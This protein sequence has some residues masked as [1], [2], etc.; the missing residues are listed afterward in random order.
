MMFHCDLDGRIPDDVKTLPEY[1]KQ[2]GYFTAKLCGNWRIIPTYGHARGYDQF[3]YQHQTVGFKAET[4]VGEVIDHIEAFRDTNQF[5]W[6][7][8]GDLHDVADGLDLSL[9][10][11]NRIDVTDRALEKAGETSAKQRYSES[12]IG[13]YKKMATHVDTML[14][15]LYHYLEENYRDDE[16]VISLFSDH[17]QSYLVPDAA[18]FLGKE[19]ARVAFM[20]RGGLT[21][22]E[23]DEI[24]STSDY[25]HIMCKLAGIPMQEAVT[26]GNLPVSF[27][28]DHERV[29]AMDE[30]LHPHDPYYATIFTKRYTVYFENGS[31]TNDEG[32][33]ELKDCKLDIV[34]RKG[35]AVYDERL[36]EKF[37]NIIL[38]HIAALL[39]Y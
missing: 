25:L 31:P 14:E 29:Y 5:L 27:G 19:R 11:Q 13:A 34:D 10:V 4:I 6:M 37:L 32:R 9:A 38:E 7:S 17:G 39:I 35:N 20:F 21:G 18:H 28:G 24:I 16:I 3:I 12:K 23:T 30:S 22:G 1:F 26:D 8:I 2:E 15:S 36:A 33:F